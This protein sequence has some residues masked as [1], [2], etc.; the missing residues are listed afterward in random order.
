[1]DAFAKRTTWQLVLVLLAGAVL[2]AVTFLTAR[3]GPADDGAPSAP[4]TVG[5]SDRSQTFLPSA[6][7]FRR[8][9]GFAS[10][11][12]GTVSFAVIDTSGQLRCYRCNRSYLSASVVKSMLLVGYLEEIAARDRPL[13]PSHRAFLKAMVRRSDNASADV[14][15][16]HVGDAALYRLAAQAEMT[17]FDVKGDWTSA[18]I[19]AADRVH[20]SPGSRR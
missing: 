6:D 16:D 8:A 2:L 15:Y 10:Q 17:K 14:I 7:Q 19:T 13:T 20:L 18:R 5:T 9:R 12:A 3:R 1:V 11:R 4:R